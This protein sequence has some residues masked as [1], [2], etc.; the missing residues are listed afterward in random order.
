MTYQDINEEKP[1]IFIIFSEPFSGYLKFSVITARAG[2]KTIT[3]YRL[4]F[5]VESFLFWA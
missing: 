2:I 5:I 1:N 3:G 4:R